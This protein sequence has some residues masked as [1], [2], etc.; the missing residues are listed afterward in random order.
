MLKL[1]PITALVYTDSLSADDALREIVRECVGRGWRLAGLIQHKRPKPGRPRCDM[2]LEELASG[3]RIGISQDRGSQARG[4]AL[5]VGQLLAAMEMVRGQLRIKPDLVVLNKFGIT[6]SEGG[7][8]RPLIAET[9]EAE[10]PLLIAVP[11]RNIENWRRFV[12]ELSIEHQLESIAGS[13]Q[14]WIE[15]LKWERGAI[16]GIATNAV[17]TKPN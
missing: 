4:C 12:G 1:S 14:S 8:L 6:E 9:L 10:V 5:D 11:W 15:R 16:R 7:G 3:E 17:G 2:E 13:S